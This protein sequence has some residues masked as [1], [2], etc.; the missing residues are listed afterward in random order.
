MPEPAA[1]LAPGAA[2]SPERQGAGGGS[3][4]VEGLVPLALDERALGQAAEGGPAPAALEWLPARVALEEVD[5][6][7]HRGQR[8]VVE[9]DRAAVHEQAAG[10]E[11]VEHREREPV[12]AVD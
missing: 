6:H 3:R 5:E 2:Q 11:P 9:D 8:D 1:E 4:L 7:R 12:R 10:V